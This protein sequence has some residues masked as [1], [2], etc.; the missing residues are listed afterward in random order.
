MVLLVARSS[1][2]SKYQVGGASTDRNSS[3]EVLVEEQLVAA[4]KT[5]SYAQQMIS[6]SVSMLQNAAVSP[7]N[8]P[9]V[10]PN[11][12]TSKE[13]NSSAHFKENLDW[14]G[15]NNEVNQFDKDCG[16]LLNAMTRRLLPSFGSP[17]PSY[18]NC[19]TALTY[20]LCFSVPNPD[21]SAQLCVRFTPP[22]ETGATGSSTV[23]NRQ[24]R[25]KGSGD[26]SSPGST[27]KKRP[28]IIL[29]GRFL[30]NVTTI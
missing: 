20:P 26:I 18:P 24:K 13:T 27:P 19:R 25:S 9:L 22:A 14:Y 8:W 5:E 16:F 12:S 3:S 23:Y 29:K 1:M 6:H 21:A 4:H 28:K 30:N 2:T 10:P 11:P 7:N 15:L 17:A